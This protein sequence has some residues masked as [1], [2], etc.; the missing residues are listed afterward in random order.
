ML[1]YHEHNLNAA[2]WV[3]WSHPRLLKL[4]GSLIGGTEVAGNPMWN[5][6]SKTPSNV[7]TMVPVRSQA[8]L[9]RHVL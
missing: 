2:T 5:L 4:I 7:L 1:I 9:V 3:L 6:R 8:T